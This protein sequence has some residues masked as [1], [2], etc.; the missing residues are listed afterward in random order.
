MSKRCEITG[1]GAQSGNNVSHSKRKTR[2]VFQPNLQRVSLISN[3]LGQTVN[4]KITAATLRSVDH[5]GGLDGFLLKTADS[6]LTTLA[7]KL[8]KKIKLASGPTEK[9]PAK[10]KAAPKPAAAKEEKPAASA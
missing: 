5:N 9:A 1:V 3:A 4:L 10:K 8:K 2:R 7:A 6:K